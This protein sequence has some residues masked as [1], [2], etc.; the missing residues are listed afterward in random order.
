[1]SRRLISFIVLSF[2]SLSIIT[3]I[4]WNQ[5]PIRPLRTSTTIIATASSSNNS[6]NTNL[7]S[8]YGKI[9]TLWQYYRGIRREGLSQPLSDSSNGGSQ[10]H[11]LSDN[12]KSNDYVFSSHLSQLSSPKNNSHTGDFGGKAL[13]A[14]VDPTFT[15][16]AYNNAF[17]KFYNLHKNEPIGKNV[18]SDMG[19]LKKKVIKMPSASTC[20][21]MFLLKNLEW[22]T[23]QS[24]SVI[25][26]DQDVDGGAIFQANGHNA[27][28]V[29]ILGH[30]EYVTQK[31]YNNLKRFVSQGGI[32]I[33]LDG[34]VF[35]AEVSYDRVTDT[36][37]LAKGHGW[38]FNG[39]S[40]WR[41]IDER[42]A[43][44]TR[45]WVGSNYLCYLCSIT[46]PNN[47]FGYRHHEEQY[48][49]NPKDIILLNY[50]ASMSN[51]KLASKLVVA[52]YELNYEKGRI[53][54]LGI[55]SDDIIGHG[56]FDRF[57]DSLLLKYGPRRQD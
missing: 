31:E 21:M 28:G 11:I 37:Q 19:L 48:I 27:Y 45:Q 24:N 46:F 9:C 26:T 16:T 23:T 50:N 43:N 41:S 44:E 39:K 6:V 54:S 5:T 22:V 38:A 47:P 30:Q 35:Y 29:V 3:I 34:N 51:W 49:T 4:G 10:Q 15:N 8:Y 57:L 32:M 18:T 12:N 7:Q 42:W 53:I 25:L 14:F 40:A 33:V 13:V 55:Y 56:S 20:E 36:M 52:T 17:Y 2:L 1:M